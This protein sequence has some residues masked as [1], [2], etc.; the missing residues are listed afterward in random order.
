VNSVSFFIVMAPL[1]ENG[2]RLCCINRKEERKTL[3]ALPDSIAKRDILHGAKAADSATYLTHAKNYIAAEQFSDAIDFYGKAEAVDEL[4]SLSKKFIEEG[5]TFLLLKVL[6]HQ[7]HLVEDHDIERCGE[8]A[9]K[10]GKIRYAIMA[11]QKL[12]NEDK[13]EALK[14]SISE[15]GD[16]V[17]ERE[18]ETFVAANLE[19]I[20]DEEE[21][22]D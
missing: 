6:H 5:D 12:E 18:A 7:P 19:E 20:S 3:M 17:A 11:Y 21:D 10:A 2:Q 4:R 1:L 14:D 16:I 15:D 9:E 13:V 22:E 8:N